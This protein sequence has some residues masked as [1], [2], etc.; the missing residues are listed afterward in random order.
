MASTNPLIKAVKGPIIDVIEANRKKID[1]TLTSAVTSAATYLPTTVEGAGAAFRSTYA[2]ITT[3][4]ATWLPSTVDALSV[5][6]KGTYAGIVNRVV[7]WL[8]TTIPG[9]TKLLNGLADKVV[10]GIKAA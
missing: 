2:D 10:A 5:A 7:A 1:A 8:P 9:L 6:F 3:R 4:V